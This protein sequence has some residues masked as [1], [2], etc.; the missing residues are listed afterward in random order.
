[1]FEHIW[2]WRN[3]CLNQGNMYV[4]SIILDIFTPWPEHVNAAADGPGGNHKQAHICQ[5]ARGQL[6]VIISG[7]DQCV[8]V[9]RLGASLERFS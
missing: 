9:F 7:K 8:A 3:V 6:M 2:K 1:M 4:S 5:N